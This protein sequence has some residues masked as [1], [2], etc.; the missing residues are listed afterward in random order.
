MLQNSKQPF[1]WK[2]I[3]SNTGVIRNLFNIN[4]KSKILKNYKILGTGQS[5]LPSD[6]Y[7]DLL[8]TKI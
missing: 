7:F 6:R 8:E 1:A 5:F 4:Y 3:K 2:K